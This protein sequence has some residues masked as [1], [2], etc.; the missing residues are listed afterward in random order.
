MNQCSRGSII[1]ID[2]HQKVCVRA[3]H[4]STP[5]GESCSSSR[6][7]FQQGEQQQGFERTKERTTQTKTLAL[8]T[9]QLLQVED[10]WH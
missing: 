4:I 6:K 7:G 9:M 8:I 10:Q 3:T 1:I 2:S 5:G